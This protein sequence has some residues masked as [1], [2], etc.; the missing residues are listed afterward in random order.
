MS[1]K[2]M[3]VI[4]H[5]MLRAELHDLKQCQI[6]FLTSSVVAAGLLLSIPKV[7]QERGLSNDSLRMA[8]LVPLV[9]VIPCWWGFFDKAKTI[10]RIVGYYRVLEG[11]ILDA[12]TA[13]RFY[14]WENALRIFRKAEQDGG[15]KHSPKMRP[16]RRILRALKSREHWLRFWRGLLLLPSQRYWLLAQWTFTILG[17]VSVAIPAAFIS[18]HAS[19]W[20]FWAVLCSGALVLYTF[21]WN[22]AILNELMYDT[23]SY[24][25]NA[26]NWIDLLE[27]KSLLDGVR[28]GSEE[29]QIEP[30][31]KRAASAGNV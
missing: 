13:R 23:H 21:C 5:G 25:A 30:P 12:Y 19:S 1:P 15:L 24:N 8:Y 3:A 16:H 28:A 22:M 14:G 27:V 7:L 18:W 11:I 20:Q 10:T 2:E 17:L 9:V 29:T 26:D 4:E 31:R 6:R